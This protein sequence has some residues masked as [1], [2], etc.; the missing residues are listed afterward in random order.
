MQSLWVESKLLCTDHLLELICSAQGLEKSATAL[1]KSTGR[2]CIAA[3]ADV[4]KPEQLEA[5]VSKARSELGKINHVICGAAG[6]LY[7]P[8]RS[9]VQS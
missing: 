9:L 8:F 4:R 5:A 1:S 3:P 2:R 7:V 6:N